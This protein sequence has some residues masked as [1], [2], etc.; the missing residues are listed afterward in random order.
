MFS[1]VGNGIGDLGSNPG[2]L[3]K[4]LDSSLILPAVAK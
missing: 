2:I 1:F 4:G 3:Q